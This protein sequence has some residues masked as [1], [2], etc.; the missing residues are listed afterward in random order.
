MAASYL[1]QRFAPGRLG[2]AQGATIT[3]QAVFS[4]DHTFIPASLM[5]F[6]FPSWRRAALL[7]VAAGLPLAAARAQQRPA[8]P[9][10]WADDAAARLATTGSQYASWLHHYRPVTLDLAALRPVLAAAPLEGSAAAARG[11]ATAVVAIPLPDGTT[12]R[13]RLV[14]A[15]VMEPALAAQFPQIKTYAGVGLDDPTASIRCDLT[16]LGFH[17]QILSVRTGTIYV[18]PV[19]PTDPTHYLS[20]YRYYMNRPARAQREGCGFVPPTDDEHPLDDMARPADH[21]YGGISTDAHRRVTISAGNTLRTY[22]LALAANREYVLARGG[23]VTSALASMTTTMNR[24]NG[25]FEKELAVRLMMIANTNLLIT[26]VAGTYANMNVSQMLG[27][28]QTRCD[29]IIGAANYDIGHVFGTGNGGVAILGCVCQNGQ[30][31]RGVTGSSSPTGDA[32]DIDYVAHEMGHQF[33]GRHPFNGSSGSCAGGNRSAATSWEPGSGSTIMAYAGICSPQDLQGNS[34]DYFHSGN[35]QEIQTEIGTTS[36]FTTT[37]TGNTAPEV[38]APSSGKTI[39]RST[40]FRLIAVGTDADGD[41]LTYNWEDMD[42]GGAQGAAPSNATNQ[43]ANQ[44][45]PLFRS[46]N[47]TTSP[48]RYFPQLNK[49]INGTTPVVGE[50]L[51]TVNRTLKFRCTVRDEHVATGLGFVVGGVN[52]SPTL[53]MTVTNQAGPFVVLTPSSPGSAP[54]FVGSP[55]TVTWD[56]ANTTA[57][58]VSCAN[59]DIILSRDGGL[60]Y[61]DTLAANVPNSGSATFNVPVSVVPTT[62]ARVMVHARN[63]FF[64]DIS[65][66]NFAVNAPQ[67]PDYALSVSPTTRSACDGAP[68]VFTLDIASLA[69]YTTPVDLTLSALPVG[70]TAAFAQTTVVPGAA[71]TTL[72]LTPSGAAAGT[73][74]LTL[75]ATSGTNVKTATITLTVLPSVT[76]ATTLTGPA[77]AATAQSLAPVFTW[78]ALPAAATYTFELSNNAAFAGP[79]LLAMPN[80]TGTTYTLAGFPLTSATTYYWR[81]RG[82]N[83]CGA[84]PDATAFSFTTATVGCALAAAPNLPRP[85]SSAAIVESLLP[86][87]AC[88]TVQ[89]INI[90]N[91]RITYANTADLE[92]YLVSPTGLSALVALNLCPNGA[93]LN[94]NFDDQA[95]G[96]YTAIPCP[97]TGGGTFQSFGGLARFNGTPATGI[98][99]LRIIDGTSA[100]S[101]SLVSWTLDICTSEVAPAAPTAL[102]APTYNDN[103]VELAWTD[104]ACNETQQLIERSIGGNTTYL[105]LATVAADATTYLDGTTAPSTQYCYRVRATTGSQQSAFAPEVCVTTSALGLTADALGDHLT[106]APNP[107]SGEFAL[108]LTGAPLGRTYLTVFDALGRTVR[109]AALTGTGAALNH[110][111]DLRAQ[112]EG[113][114]LLRVTLPDGRT[115]VRRL[116]KM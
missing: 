22:R 43:T 2:H 76:T 3:H 65:N 19:S 31:A 5:S 84:G 89:D 57:A 26:T 72:S 77:D 63:N 74:P 90:K 45:D 33:G 82:E 14:E 93:N 41:P 15:P 94:L 27:Q 108:T 67:A 104:N 102:R 100:R 13:F 78:A 36:C 58:P 48:I 42:T 47:A 56:V 85:I 21:A 49:I 101:G 116:V 73:Y 54:W 71:P 62:R 113:V 38:T 91:L 88:G 86:I 37:P 24:V 66:A 109:T 12:G 79:L 35:F 46:F 75:T 16:P 55:A 107:S 40:P 28:N 7:V 92:I 32:F 96:A 25:V 81:V 18:D 69:G 8:P 110:T 112:A 4:S 111:L 59:V 97:A 23:T 29:Q 80:L 95:A 51:P 68:A 1:R 52:Y 44:R 98:W 20:F 61:T 10:P 115:G 99:K 106:V 105:P 39:P 70:V 114:Y 103:S 11:V 50:A 87:T 64:F 83:G 6:C 34:D 53:T 60:S 30:K 17:A 9:T